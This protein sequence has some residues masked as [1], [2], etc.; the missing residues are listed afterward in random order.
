MFWPVQYLLIIAIFVAI[1]RSYS[2]KTGVA[3]LAACF[4]IQAAD[5]SKGWLQN[6]E[7]L[8]RFQPYDS[9]AKTLSNVFWKNAPAHYRHLTLIPAVNRPPNW[10]SFAIYAATNHLTTDAVHMARIDLTKQEQSNAKLNQ[11]INTGSFDLDTLYIVENR[12]VIAALAT[13]PNNTAIAKIDTFN[14]VAPNWNACGTCPSIDPTL[15]LARDRYASKPGEAISFATTSPNR[16]YY[17]RQ[18][19][20]WSEDWGTWSDG[21]FA[22]L[23]FSWPTSKAKSLTLKFDTFVIEDKHPTQEIDVTVNGI[24][25]SKMILNNPN[26]LQL[27]IVFTPEMQNAKFLSIEFKLNSPARPADLLPNHPDQRM[28]GIGLRTAVFQ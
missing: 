6:R 16:T 8:A 17:L 12:F 24:T 7:Q 10:E 21:D 13:A 18:G 15:I 22:A 14:V 3:I 23:N 2:H 11:Q 20:S 26:D 9:Y 4:L 25:H 1:V 28:L 5:T 27:K 19:W